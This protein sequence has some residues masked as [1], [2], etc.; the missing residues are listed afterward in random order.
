MPRSRSP[1]GQGGQTVLAFGRLSGTTYAAA[2]RDDPGYCRWAVTVP[3]PSGPLRH[4]ANYVRRRWSRGPLDDATDDEEEEEESLAPSEGEEEAHGGLSDSDGFGSE[5]EAA[6][7]SAKAKKKTAAARIVDD[8]PRVP[9][10]AALFTGNPHPESCPICLET[11]AEWEEG[12]TQIVLTPCFH[13]FHAP[14]LGGWLEKQ[15][16]CPSCRWDITDTGVRQVLENTGVANLT[17]KLSSLAGTTVV[18]SDS[19]NDE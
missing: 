15:R 13:V 5:S 6:G 14:C 4:F 3:R 11:F 7:E 10:N 2:L 19:D 8:L 9:F 18:V 17:P 1:R 16:E 12:K